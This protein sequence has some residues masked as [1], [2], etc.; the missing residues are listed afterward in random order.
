MPHDRRTLANRDVRI[1]CMVLQG[2]LCLA[3]LLAFAPTVTGAAAADEGLP[4]QQQIR[5]LYDRGEYSDVLRQLSRVLIL[6]DKAAEPYDRHELLR[7]KGEIHLRQ[8]GGTKLAGDAFEDAS[9]EATDGPSAA[10]DIAMSMLVRR[11]GVGLKY[12]TRQT[13]P[14]DK[15]R[16]LSPI[17]IVDPASRKKAVE[18]LFADEWTIVEAKVKPLRT[19]RAVTP[20]LEALPQIRNLRWLEMAATGTDVKSQALVGD[21]VEPTK[22]RM[23]AA[24]DEMQQTL[25]PLDLLMNEVLQARVP[26]NDNITGKIVGFDLKWRRR[27]P[28]P[29]QAAQLRDMFDTAGKVFASCD[30]LGGSLGKTGREFDDVKAKAE[31][32]GIKLKRRLDTD[33]RATFD[34]PPKPVE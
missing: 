13:D 25:E 32:I 31:V 14:A 12:E 15:T 20:L 34:T 6:K 18:A 17:D 33:W 30:L 28:F 3:A 24:M 7:M 4:S 1:H 21:L 27:G 22:K 5:D 29:K 8:T 11:S 23:L 16:R 9:K 2:C 26:V 10:A 19:S